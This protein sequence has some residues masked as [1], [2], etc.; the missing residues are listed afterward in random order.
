MKTGR[1]LLPC[2]LLTSLTIALGASTLLTWA[3]G[4]TAGSAFAAAHPEWRILKPSNTGIPGEEVGLVRVAPDGRVWVAAR[5]PFWQQGGLSVLDPATG[6]WTAYA[7]WETPLPSIYVND[8]AFADKGVVWIA[9]DAGL[10]KKDG[11]AWT[12]YTTANAPLVHDS[13]QSIDLD[14][15]GHVW[16]NNSRPDS[17][18]A[19]LF[20][21]DGST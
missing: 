1:S 19:A 14:A 8:V 4:T 11:D 16:V 9:T 7:S 3:E 2:F 17:S 20:D 6:V 5:W 13:I 15:R 18:A 12:V 21:F 10:V